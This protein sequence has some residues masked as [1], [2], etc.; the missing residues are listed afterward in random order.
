MLHIAT[1]K[2]G[3]ALEEF[4]KRLKRRKNKQLDFIVM[5]MSSAFSC[6]ARVNFP[7]TTVVIDHFHVI[8][9]MNGRVDRVRRRNVREV[10]EMV[11]SCDDKESKSILKD[12]ADKLKKTKYL[13]LYSKENLSEKEYL[14]RLDLGIMYQEVG[15]AVI[16]R[17]MLQQIYRNSRGNVE[18]RDALVSWCQECRD[19]EV[20]ELIS[21]AKTVTRYLDSIVAY[22]TS[23]GMNNGAHEG[24]NNKVRKLNGVA[25]G[26][27]DQE[28]FWLRIYDLPK[29]RDYADVY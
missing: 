21:M 20:P 17:D 25:Y 26:Y 22:W 18:A 14:R 5:D 11:N 10:K 13:L 29:L 15:S 24:F 8:K 6:W 9:L 3:A 4:G 2:G 7:K 12:E 23:G 27:K 28:Y 16:M 19:T 1:G